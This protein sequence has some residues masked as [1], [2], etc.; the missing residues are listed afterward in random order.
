MAKPGERWFG[1]D[2]MKE[3]GLSEGEESGVEDG[4]EPVELIRFGSENKSG[5]QRE[6]SERER[7]AQ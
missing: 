3:R 1:W 4:I 2:L 5:R 7:L 6:Q